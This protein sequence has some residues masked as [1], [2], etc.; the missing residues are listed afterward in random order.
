MA[1]ENENGLSESNKEAAEKFKAEAN[2]YFRQ[3]KFS[4]AEELY[5]KAIDINPNN[6]VYF[7][8]RSI[9]HLKQESFGYALADASKAI[10]LDSTYTKAYYRYFLKISPFLYNKK[11]Q[12][13]YRIIKMWDQCFLFWCCHG[14]FFYLVIGMDYVVWIN[15]FV[16]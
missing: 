15:C 6:A 10:E 3:E 11:F 8:N 14:S 9:T 12:S 16:T 13:R 1:S 2:E 4:A 5:S 7:A